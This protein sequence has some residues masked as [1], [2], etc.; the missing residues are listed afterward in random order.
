MNMK[1]IKKKNILILM[2]VALVILHI[3]P[4]RYISSTRVFIAPFMLVTC[5]KPWVSSHGFCAH[6]FAYDMHNPWA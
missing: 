3:E 2:I 5:T 1:K 4:P 6:V